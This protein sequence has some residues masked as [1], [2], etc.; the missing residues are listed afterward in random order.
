MIPH[1]RS[2]VAKLKDE[3]FALVGMNSDPKENLR[4][5]MAD[6]KITWRSFWDG[7]GTGGPIATRWNVHSWPTIYVLDQNGVIRA[8]DL[9]DDALE[10]KVEEL[11][12]AMKSPAANPNGAGGSGGQ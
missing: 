7:G 12:A 4:K 3:P 11:L 5:A 8:R 2:L 1:E 6:E 9:R 10:K